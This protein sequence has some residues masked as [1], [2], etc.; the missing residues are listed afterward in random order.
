MGL[1]NRGSEWEEYDNAVK[2]MA[3][4]MIIT[5]AIT[6]VLTVFSLPLAFLIEKGISKNT[7]ATVKAFLKAVQNSPSFLFNQYYSWMQKLSS[8]NEFSLGRWVPILPIISLPVGL[9][10]GMIT[11]PYHFQSNVH[12]SA[13]I[14]TLRD[15]N[16]ME[17]LGFDGFCQVVGKFNGRLLLLKETLSTNF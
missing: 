4:T 6:L 14:A 7:I 8:G 2:W 17:L 9:I 10:T 5:L 1:R 12:G 11:C 3:M 13:R 15:I 16:K